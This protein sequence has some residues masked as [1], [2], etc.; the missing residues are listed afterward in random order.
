MPAFN[1]VR[2]PSEAGGAINS[3]WMPTRASGQHGRGLTH[4]NIIKTGERSY[5][6]IA[7]WEDMD[8]CIKARP[9]MI[10][11]LDSF[12]RDARR[13]RRRSRRHR[14][15]GRCG[16]LSAKNSSQRGATR[17]PETARAA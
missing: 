14:C 13:P 17:P 11:T 2:F 1:A 3:S 5:C 9:N 8:A 6:L 12:S 10:A 4:A 15:G 16:H 7:E